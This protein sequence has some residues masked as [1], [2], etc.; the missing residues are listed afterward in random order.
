MSLINYRSFARPDRFFDD[1]IS[2]PF[3]AFGWD[4]AVDVY[5][6]QNQVIV[7]MTVPGMRTEGFDIAIDGEVLS[8]SGEREEEEE[9]EEKEYYS[10]EIRRGAFSRLIDLPCAV[11]ETKTEAEYKNGVLTVVLPKLPTEEK[12][13]TKIHVRG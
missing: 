2:E 7:K 5:E 11:D 4:M 13:G 9:V 6:E 1:S 12:K 8:V 3:R 10:K